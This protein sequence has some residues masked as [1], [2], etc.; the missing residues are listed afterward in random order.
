MALQITQSV[1]DA[2]LALR[3]SGDVAGSWDILSE[4]G[5]LYAA[6]ARDIIYEINNPVTVFAKIVQVHWDRVA[7]GARQTVFFDVGLQHLTQYLQR[8]RE[9]PSGT[10]ENGEQ[11]YRLPSSEQIEASY[12]LAVIQHG[13]PAIT[14]VDSLFSVMDWNLERSLEPQYVLARMAGAEDISWA[15]MLHPELEDARVVFD[16]TTFL[17]D[18]IE[19]YKETFRTMAAMLQRAYD[20]GE[21][22]FVLAA[23]QLYDLLI[24]VCEDTR[25][26]CC[27]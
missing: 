20:Q 12:R 1:F 8:I 2:A 3:D 4:A 9:E 19:P 17:D 6:N 25:K 18:N 11:L 23:A 16:A 26:K 13:L 15:Q 22:D 7:P 5:D 27:P 21:A 10:N 14:A 24:S